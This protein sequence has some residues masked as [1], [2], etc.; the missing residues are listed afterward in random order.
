MARAPLAGTGEFFAIRAEHIMANRVVKTQGRAGLRE[1]P[2][3]AT[4]VY[5]QSAR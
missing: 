3:G 2:P 4:T 1:V 5:V